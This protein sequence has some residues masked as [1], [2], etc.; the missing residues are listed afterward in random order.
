MPKEINT[1]GWMRFAVGLL[2]FGILMAIG[3]AGSFAVSQSRMAVIEAETEHTKEA[4][5][6]IEAKVDKL[7][8]FLRNPVRP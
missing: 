5:V 6:R 4:L 2:T 1:L 3:S 8:E 7:D